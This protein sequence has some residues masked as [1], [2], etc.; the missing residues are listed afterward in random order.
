MKMRVYE[1]W[2]G[3]LV[4]LPASLP[5]PHALKE[6]GELLWLGC[7]SIAFDGLSSDLSAAIAQWGYGLADVADE[8]LLRVSLEPV[9]PD[10]APGRRPPTPADTG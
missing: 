2:D 9:A 10:L 4:V 7:A 1:R 3:L 8:A 6:E 5:L